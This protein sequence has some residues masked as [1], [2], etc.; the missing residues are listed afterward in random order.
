MR[1]YTLH[2]YRQFVF[3]A[4]CLVLLVLA[5][6]MLWPFWHAFAWGTALAI[7]VYPLH[8]RL[9]QRFNDSLAAGITTGLVI[10]FILGPLFL[11]G[12]GLYGEA[13]TVLNQLRNHSGSSTALQLGALIDRINSFVAPYAQ[14]VGIDDFD[15]RE[16]VRRSL[17]SG[18][19]NA[20]L[21]VREVL[22]GVLTAVFTV[23]LLFFILRDSHKLK[24]PALDLIPLPRE[25]AEEAMRS[26]YDTVHAIFYGVLLVA[27][28]QGGSLGMTFWLLGLPSPL[29]WGMAG[30][31]LCMIP[32][33]GAPLIYV[34][35]ALL[36]ISHGE[37]TK[38]I[39]LLIV[40]MGFISLIDNFFRPAII[41]ARIRRHYAAVFF[42]LVGGVVTLGPVGLLIGPVVLS[43]IL[44]AIQVLRGMALE[45]LPDPPGDSRAADDESL[46]P[47]GPLRQPESPG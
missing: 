6:W 32:F 43:L 11:I 39:I 26:I 23:I 5:I 22:M 14:Q 4:I 13:K 31:V 7:L 3:A 15:L 25:A 1:L 24:E 9:T 20:R 38:A 36:L 47:Q 17:E 18:L 19:G 42:S 28:A 33:A 29:V 12:L 10:L 8:L 37:W 44:G 45:A 16:V 27:I 46:S 21:L 34:P 2:R 35:T 30:V 41:G 40:G